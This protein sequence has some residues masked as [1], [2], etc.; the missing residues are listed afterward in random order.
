MISSLAIAKL[1]ARRPGLAEFICPVFGSGDAT[2]YMQWA[3]NVDLIAARVPIT[4]PRY[5]GGS[6]RRP[7]PLGSDLQNL[8][9]LAL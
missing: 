6:V 9:I 4:V 8:P 1:F 3:P 7:S 5:V 2:R